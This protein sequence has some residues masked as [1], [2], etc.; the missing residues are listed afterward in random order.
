[1]FVAALAARFVP[2]ALLFAG[3]ELRNVL[4][5]NWAYV[6]A[7]GLALGALNAY[8]TFAKGWAGTD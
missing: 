5:V 7:A 2:D 1:M 8:L 4:V 6:L 3:D